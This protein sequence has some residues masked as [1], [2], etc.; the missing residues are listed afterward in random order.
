MQRHYSARNAPTSTLPPRQPFKL[1]LENN[2]MT[3]TIADSEIS[4]G[5][6]SSSEEILA[7]YLAV[8]YNLRNVP[9][10]EPIIFRQLDLEVLSTALELD[11]ADIEAKLQ[12]LV[13]NK[14]DVEVAERKFR[15]RFTSS[16]AGVILA[17][18]AAGLLVANI[19]ATPEPPTDISTAAVMTLEIVTDIGNGGAIEFNSES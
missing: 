9:I 2:F 19:T 6:I 18:C 10:G 8:I 11:L 12:Q 13:D 4:A 3:M 15:S 5:D 17:V 16:V 14:T 7:R 1:G